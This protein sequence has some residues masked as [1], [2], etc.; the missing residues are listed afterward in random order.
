MSEIINKDGVDIEVFTAEE[1]EAQ[2]Q[3]AI[4]QYK[5]DN[6]DKTDE[7]TALQ[8]ELREKE[9]EIEKAKGKDQNFEKLRIA[10]DTAEKKVADILAGVDDKITKAKAEV[11][12]G[13]MKD[14]Y[15]ETLNALSGGDEELKKKIEFNFKRLGDVA[16]T[17]AE[18]TAKFQDAA[19]LAGQTDD[20]VNTSVFSS[21][22]VGR[23]NIK[24][25]ETK[26]SADEKVLASKLGLS[27]AELKKYNA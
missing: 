8:E 10:K 19:R 13:V 23:L 16:S 25:S 15:N 9:E 12:E 17:K 3:E 27:E 5:L 18:I 24:G 6:P 21:G 26:L 11:F 20:A 7:L 22:G 14:H 4:E 2:K 1:I